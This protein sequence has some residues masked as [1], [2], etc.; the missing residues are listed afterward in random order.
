[1]IKKEFRHRLQRLRI[2]IY[3]ALENDDIT[4]GLFPALFSVYSYIYL[5]DIEDLLC[6]RCKKKK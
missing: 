1:M 6:K 4:L 5:K 2:E 3:R